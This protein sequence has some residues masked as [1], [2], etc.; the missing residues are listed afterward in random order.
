VKRGVGISTVVIIGL[1]AWWLMQRQ[2]QA[3]A[4]GMSEVSEYEKLHTTVPIT[5]S[6]ER[7][8]KVY[9]E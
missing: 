5:A 1:V 6:T 2:K 9:G 8:F 4:S 7:L 3:Q